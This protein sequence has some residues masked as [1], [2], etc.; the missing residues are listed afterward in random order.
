MPSELDLLK[1]GYVW[2]KQVIAQRNRRKREKEY[3][4]PEAKAKRVKA[5]VVEWKRQQRIQ[6]YVDIADDPVAWREAAYESYR[7]MDKKHRAN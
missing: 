3:N 2:P 1:E 7:R 5:A 4:S 6:K